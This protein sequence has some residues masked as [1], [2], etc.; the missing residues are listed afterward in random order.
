LLINRWQ[1]QGHVRYR[2]ASFIWVAKAKSREEMMMMGYSS[3]RYLA[4]DCLSEQL[5]NPIQIYL[6]PIYLSIYLFTKPSS[7]AE[8]A[9]S[10][11][12]SKYEENTDSNKVFSSKPLHYPIALSFL[13]IYVYIKIHR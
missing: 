10:P 8:R 5:C 12:Q 4:M 9:N 6:F 11:M 1:L 2:K 7:G 3:S 13:S